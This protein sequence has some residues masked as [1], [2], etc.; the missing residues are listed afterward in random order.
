M[1]GR[2]KRSKA[3]EERERTKTECVELG[4]EKTSNCRFENELQHDV[5][6]SDDWEV[7]SGT[8]HQGYAHFQYPGVQCTYI[9][10]WALVYMNVK[11]PSSWSA[12]DVDMCVIDGNAGFIEHC[13][14]RK[15]QPQMLLAKELP[16]CIRCHGYVWKCDQLDDE[17]KVGT[18]TPLSV[19]NAT[20]GIS[21]T[22]GNALVKC[23]CISDA[24]LFFC[25][26]Q[27]IAIAKQ[28]N[29]IYIFDP[30]SRGKD[31]LLH[32]SGNAVLVS[33]NEIQRL[34]KF[35]ERLMQ[36]LGLKSSELFEL[37]PIRISIQ[38]HA[39]DTSFN[40]TAD[41]D[42]G[43][44][45][46]VPRKSDEAKSAVQ[47]IVKG[48]SDDK[49]KRQ[50]SSNQ[51][52]ESYFADQNMRDKKH[53]EKRNLET[54]SDDTNID[55]KQYMRQY[56]QKRRENESFRKQSNSIAVEG[57]KRIR[58]TT[59]G[60][61]KNNTKAVEGMKKL[62]CTQ[63]GKLKHNQMSNKTMNT[64]LSTEEGR[65]KHKEMSAKTRKRMR[66]AEEGRQSYNAR[67]NERMKKT[68][69]TEEGRKRHNARSVEGMRKML[70]TEKG[71]K[72]HNASSA[73][74]MKNC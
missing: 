74:T 60:K 35:I 21:E 48:P 64:M 39:K 14:E 67:S 62:L 46:H 2:S 28:R 10:F 5:R 37:V 71:G 9:S 6:S 26:G 3:A 38:P 7:V 18:L 11:N 63:E 24:I 27:T 58:A 65:Q 12:N 57:M 20:V 25:G 19:N 42:P 15:L 41:N 66:S 73:E 33:F 29:K 30:H 36:S 40:A 55:R 1:P 4:I 68:L 8:L 43:T 13:F 44:T 69:S 50:V 22:L 53:K 23:F 49:I 56:M 70:S 51:A 34:I 32:H 17:I 72:K 31:G 59:E 16:Q 54:T 47:T 61:R 45:G 52:I